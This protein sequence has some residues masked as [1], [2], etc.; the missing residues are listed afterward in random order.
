MLAQGPAAGKQT[1][2][3]SCCVC[4]HDGHRL[5]SSCSAQSAADLGSVLMGL[6]APK[7]QAAVVADSVCGLC[8]P[9]QPGCCAV[10]GQGQQRSG[11]FGRH[12]EGT[13]LL[14]ALLQHAH[15]VLLD[16]EGS[17]SARPV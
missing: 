7:S 1:Y 9:A 11:A 10:T 5:S 13:A 8:G 16:K 3:Y 15:E 14:D 12:G 6:A 2:F 4:G 17:L